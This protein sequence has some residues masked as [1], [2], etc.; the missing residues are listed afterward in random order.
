[1]TNPWLSIQPQLTV[2]LFIYSRKSFKSNVVNRFNKKKIH[3]ATDL[4]AIKKLKVFSSTAEQNGSKKKW[5]LRAGKL[6]DP[7]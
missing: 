1:M 4:T 7:K 5:K 2:Y 3:K 6:K